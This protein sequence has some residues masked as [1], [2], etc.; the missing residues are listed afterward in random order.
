VQPVPI[1]FKKIKKTAKF[2]LDTG[3]LSSWAESNNGNWSDDDN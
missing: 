1:E 2:V 3:A